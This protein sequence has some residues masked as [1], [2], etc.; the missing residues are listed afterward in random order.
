MATLKFA[1]RPRPSP[2]P[3]TDAI[4]LLAHPEKAALSLP[5]LPGPQPHFSALPAEVRVMIYKYLFNG[6]NVGMD[7]ILRSHTK[8]DPSRISKLTNILRVN[9]QCHA[10]A[11]PIFYDRVTFTMRRFPH[12]CSVPPALRTPSST[13]ITT[14]NI[15]ELVITQSN[16]CPFIAPLGELFPSLRRVCVEVLGKPTAKLSVRPPSKS[17]IRMAKKVLNIYQD[18]RIPLSMP[19]PVNAACASRV[20]SCYSTSS[21]TD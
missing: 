11:W 10:E 14:A 9:R 8:I 13:E 19:H 7:T 4:A 17:S 20:L 12:D 15:R 2:Y 1:Y 21:S 18:K 16:L 6:D 3:S 5:H